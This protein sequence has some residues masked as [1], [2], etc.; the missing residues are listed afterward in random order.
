MY[1][2]ETLDCQQCGEVVRELSNYEA[3]QV[4][5]AP[6]NFVVYCRWCQQDMKQANSW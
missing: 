5:R 3:Q 6:Y 4:A 1:E 2:N